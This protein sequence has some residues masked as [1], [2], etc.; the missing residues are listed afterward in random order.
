M[1]RKNSN[2][3]KRYPSVSEWAFVPAV[4]EESL[5]GALEFDLVRGLDDQG[6]YQTI[7]LRDI[8]DITEVSFTLLKLEITHLDSSIHPGNYLLNI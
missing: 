4:T 6:E 1:E 7:Y 8:Q 3:P 2:W 5:L